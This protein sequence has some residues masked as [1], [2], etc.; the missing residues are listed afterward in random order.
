MTR[1]WL[2]MLYDKYVIQL[3]IVLLYQQTVLGQPNVIIP[4]PFNSIKF[5]FR[6]VNLMF[7]AL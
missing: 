7:K 3:L 1:Q 6:A 4:K 5:I 2:G